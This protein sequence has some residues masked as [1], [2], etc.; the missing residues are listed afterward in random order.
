[1]RK[2]CCTSPRNKNIE[3]RCYFTSAHLSRIRL[4][5]ETL[6][7]KHVVKLYRIGAHE[8]MLSRL[9]G[10]ENG[11]GITS[12]RTARERGRRPSSKD[13]ILSRYGASAR[14]ASGGDSSRIG[15]GSGLLQL[16]CIN[17]VTHAG[18]DPQWSKEFV[19]LNASKR[20]RYQAAHAP[21][22]AALDPNKYSHLSSDSAQY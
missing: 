21:H 4:V 12:E 5:V 22:I 13:T 6:C 11:T 16:C 18:A 1:M 20:S 7:T 9:V 19:Q 8:S 17:G 14:H 3:R 2:L 15:W 10:M